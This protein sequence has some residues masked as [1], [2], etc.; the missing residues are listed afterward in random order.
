MTDHS[1]GI[2]L[3]A[4]KA[5]EIPEKNAVGPRKKPK[6]NFE[7]VLAKEGRQ[8]GDSSEKKELTD[9]PRPTKGKGS[10]ENEE[11]KLEAYDTK[12]QAKGV[13]LFELAS[14]PVESVDNEV[15][16]EVSM[17]ETEE[18]ELPVTKISEEVQE[19]SLSA[20]FKGYGTKEKLQS[21]QLEAKEMPPQQPVI[22]KESK[23]V[24]IDKT[25]AENNKGRKETFTREQPD[26][27]S[28][29]PIADH[30]QVA[31]TTS[32]QSPT[33]ERP[34]L[35]PQ[36]I[37]EIVSQ[38]VEKIATVETKGKTDTLITL[39]H[40]PMFAGSSVV[41]RSFDTAKG[42]FNI[43]FENLTQA[44][45]QLIETQESQNSLKSALEQKGYTVH[46]VTAT[47]LSDTTRIVE[48]Q[49]S[50]R[51]NSEDKEDSSEKEREEDA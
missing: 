4:N 43:T 39:R 22:P 20:L 13:S 51:S 10:F 46:I 48:G 40:P 7:K 6:K 21:F 45:K 19:E 44:A 41:I 18:M 37:K 27:S 5:Q 1:F 35:T 9:S 2:N 34:R 17:T 14:D 33:V 26:L 11:I 47:T 3:N 49:N 12:P 24:A 28:I 16:L 42:E 36:Q 32:I 15:T 31:L 23:P 29:N 50:E 8:E 38:I 25:I 30:T